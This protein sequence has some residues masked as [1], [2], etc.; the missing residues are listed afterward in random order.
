[1]HV[2]QII[3]QL[4]DRFKNEEL[5][6]LLQVELLLGDVQGLEYTSGT[7]HAQ[8]RTQAINVPPGKCEIEASHGPL[9]PSFYA[10]QDPKESWKAKHNV[11]R[12]LYMNKILKTSA[13]V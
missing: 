12:V 8:T 9:Q 6:R 13:M 5:A 2:F 1:M 10:Q 4:I 11:I 3:S 7:S